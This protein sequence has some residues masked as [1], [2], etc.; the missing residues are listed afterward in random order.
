MGL[1]LRKRLEQV[2]SHVFLGG[3]LLSEPRS[4]AQRCGGGGRPPEPVLWASEPCVCGEPAQRLLV[5]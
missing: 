4:S 3:H 2:V 5:M 1:R